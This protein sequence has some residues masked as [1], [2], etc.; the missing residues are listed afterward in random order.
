MKLDMV[1]RHGRRIL[2][3]SHYTCTCENSCSVNMS[4]F[5]IK[6][7]DIIR[8]VIV[9][10]TIKINGYNLKFTFM[11]IID[12]KPCYNVFRYPLTSWYPFLIIVSVQQHF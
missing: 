10:S 5:K 2:Q 12:F 7:Y 3:W 4:G 8:K 9:L 1:C 6:E 11:L